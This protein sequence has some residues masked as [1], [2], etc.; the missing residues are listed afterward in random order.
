MN[1]DLSQ[2]KA[3]VCG[4]TQGMGRA[5]A[6][7]LATLGATVTLVARNEDSLKTVRDALRVIIRLS[8]QILVK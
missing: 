5:A 1:I 8:V 6:E 2:R 3:I 7:E 4:A